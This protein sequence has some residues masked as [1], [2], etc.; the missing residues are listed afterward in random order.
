MKSGGDATE[1]HHQLVDTAHQPFAYG[2]LVAG[3]RDSIGV[4]TNM[5]QLRSEIRLIVRLSIVQP[6]ERASQQDRQR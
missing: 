5:D 1:V 3:E 2:I 4:L 6:D